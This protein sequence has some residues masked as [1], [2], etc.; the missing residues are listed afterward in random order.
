MRGAFGIIALLVVLPAAA[1][2]APVIEN[3]VAP[4]RATRDAGPCALDAAV[5]GSVLRCRLRWDDAAR[6]LTLQIE[7]QAP[8]CRTAAVHVAMTAARPLPANVQGP[9]I[10]NATRPERCAG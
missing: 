1:H 8:R 2:A 6:P 7:A 9:V 3:G 10:E 5:E 4:A